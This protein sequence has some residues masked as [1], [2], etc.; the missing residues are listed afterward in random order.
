[1]TFTVKNDDGTICYIIGIRKDI[2]KAIGKEPGDTVHVE[3]VPA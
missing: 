3:I 2:R 1:M